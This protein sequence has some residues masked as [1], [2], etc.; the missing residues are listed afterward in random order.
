[1]TRALYFFIFFIFLDEWIT[2]STR[3]S[4]TLSMS[5][6]NFIWAC[7]DFLSKIGCIFIFPI[8]FEELL[9][10]SMW[11]NNLRTELKLKEVCFACRILEFHFLKILFLL[12][13]LHDIIFIMAAQI[14]TW[15]LWFFSR[16]FTSSTLL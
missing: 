6:Y 3:F 10:T 16:N 1:V 13:V 11:L 15:S 14:W 5:H 12:M 7:G 8:F 4:S 2:N 9:N